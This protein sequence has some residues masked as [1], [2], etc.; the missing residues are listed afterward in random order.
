[1]FVECGGWTLLSR[2]LRVRGLL[3]RM[4]E[5]KKSA[6]HQK[7]QPAACPQQAGRNLVP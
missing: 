4:L 5:N 3:S 7:F 6:G 2:H 1:L